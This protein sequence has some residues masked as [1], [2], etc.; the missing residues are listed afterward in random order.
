MPGRPSGQP[1][2]VT[3]DHDVERVFALPLSYQ[4]RAP[5]SR[6]LFKPPLCYL[7]VDG[8]PAS[9]AQN[10]PRPQQAMI[11]PDTI[12][13]SPLDA[14]VPSSPVEKAR[15]TK[16]A[17]P[18]SSLRMTPVPSLQRPHPQSSPQASGP[19][20]E[21]AS[22]NPCKLPSPQRASRTATTL[23]VALPRPTLA[24]SSTPGRGSGQR[25]L[26]NGALGKLNI[27]T[28]ESMRV[29]ERKGPGPLAMRDAVD[30]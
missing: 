23:L 22:P 7:R 11:Q 15:S 21:G 8:L 4:S 1:L 14:R 6:K 28:L 25:R 20:N 3:S 24:A 18:S 12:F 19:G 9:R 13:Y 30:C 10:G 29:L 5:S 26:E 16:R 2:I 27:G 17:Y